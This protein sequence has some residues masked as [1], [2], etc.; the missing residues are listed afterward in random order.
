M[1][2]QLP[3]RRDRHSH[4]EWGDADR[5]RELFDNR[6]YALRTTT[7]RF[8]FRYRS[9]QRVIVHHRAWDGPIK[10]A[11][12]ALDPDGQEILDAMLLEIY[13]ANNSATDGTVVVASD[14][15]DVVATVR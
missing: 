9:A 6:V 1:E 7:W 8:T 12:D 10:S 15:L 3:R 4:L 5:I 13:A 14:Y 11:L 2:R